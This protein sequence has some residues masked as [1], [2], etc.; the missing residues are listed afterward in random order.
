M[1]IPVVCRAC[2]SAFNAPD[3]MAGREID[4]PRC[5]GPI[6]IPAA[7]LAPTPPPPRPVVAAP[8]QVVTLAP[9]QPVYYQQP[10]PAPVAVAVTVNQPA[11]E[12]A[13]RSSLGAASLVLG[14]AMFA[15]AWVPCLGILTIPVS[16]VGL[17][18]GLAGLLTGRGGTGFSV[19]GATLCAVALAVACY[20]TWGVGKALHDAGPP[21]ALSG[22]R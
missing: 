8:P 2:K 11:A 14:V 1:P 6:F 18:L 17:L 10:A 16:A 7:P 12:P 15:F 4:C 20:V 21:P 22:D 5:N 3:P 19:A 9:P 13:H